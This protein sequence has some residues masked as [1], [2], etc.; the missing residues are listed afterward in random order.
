MVE[1]VAFAY[2]PGKSMLHRLDARVKTVALIAASVSLMAADF[3][4]LAL[5]ALFLIIGLRQTGLPLSQAC[6]LYT[7]DAADD[8]GLG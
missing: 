3:S 5:S 6:L 2:H 1:Q 8:H 7:S 4:G